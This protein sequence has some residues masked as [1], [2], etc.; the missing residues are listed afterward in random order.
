MED[1]KHAFTVTSTQEQTVTMYLYWRM[2]LQE[3][4]FINDGWQKNHLKITSYRPII[5]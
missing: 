1:D 2:I 5:L 3:G 4:L